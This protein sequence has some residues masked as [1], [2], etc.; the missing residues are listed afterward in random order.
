MKV[1]D[2]KYIFLGISGLLIVVS[3]LS[4]AVFGLRFGIDFTGGSLMEVRYRNEVP[5]IE[6]VGKNLEKLGLGSLV[7][8]STGD[9]TLLLRFEHVDE[10]KHQRI[11]QELEGQAGKGNLEELQ[12]T[13]IGP[14]IG[15]ELKRNSILALGLASMGIIAYLAYAFRDVSKPVSSWK[16]GLVA[17]LVAFMH[18]VAIPVGIF[19]VMGHYLGVSIDGLFITA[20]LTI[21]GFSVHDTIVVFD[22]IRENLR[23]LKGGEPFE[24]V[25]NRSINETLGRSINTSLTTM[26]ALAAVFFFGGVTVKYFVLAMI[27]GIFFGTYSSIF[28][29]SPLLVLWDYWTK[30]R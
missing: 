7:A 2:Y 22:R 23:K 28:V 16:Y 6:E 29:A 17:V 11:L 27:I 26:L 20:L 4:V 25:V 19:S 12:F 30:R 1:L 14:V 24:G 15:A 18:D 9:R 3:F 13:S 21:L 8:Q 10:E 5:S